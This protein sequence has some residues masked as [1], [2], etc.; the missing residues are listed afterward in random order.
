MNY[1]NLSVASARERAKET[2]VRKAL[3]ALKRQIISQFF[4]EAILVNFLALLVALLLILLTVKPF[5]NLLE[6]NYEYEML[7]QPVFGYYW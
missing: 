7:L 6:L 4:V 1:I 3:G 5:L 2:G